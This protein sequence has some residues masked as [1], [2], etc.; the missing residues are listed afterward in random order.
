MKKKYL[1]GILVV[2]FILGCI[3]TYIFYGNYQEYQGLEVD[4]LKYGLQDEYISP[5]YIVTNKEI[6]DLKSLIKQGMDLDNKIISYE[7]MIVYELGYKRSEWP[8][9]DS[10]DRNQYLSDLISFYNSQ[11]LQLDEI[12]LEL[13][14]DLIAE[15][16]SYNLTNTDLR[17]QIKYL[18]A[19]IVS[20]TIDRNYK[21]NTCNTVTIDNIVVV[22]KY[23]CVDSSYN[24]GGL[25]FQTTQAYNL[26]VADALKQGITLTILSDFRTYEYQETVFNSYVDNVGLT[27]TMKLSAIPGYSEHQL[28]E[29]IDF[30]GVNG[31]SFNACFKDTP[32]GLWLFEHA[33]EYGFILRYPMQKEDVTGYEFEPWHY[34]YVGVEFAKQLTDS[35][36]TVEEYFNFV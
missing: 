28:G 10:S 14:R 5:N 25:T 36:L 23:L 2:I 17:S 29:A 9:F 18:Y 13:E 7:M 12:K 20:N 1:I 4:V 3:P 11:K 26:M 33:F 32:E 19:T 15:Q 24:P 22:N 27:E 35:G 16:V 30:G 6:S 31:C 21:R 8:S 34:R